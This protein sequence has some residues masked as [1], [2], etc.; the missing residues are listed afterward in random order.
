MRKQHGPAM[1]RQLAVGDAAHSQTPM[2][3]GLLLC[4]GK[5]KRMG[6]DKGLLRLQG[7]YYA[8]ICLEQLSAVVDRVFVSVREDQAESYATILPAA[9]LVVDGDVSA[10]GPLRGL[11]SLLPVLSDAP[12]ESGVLVLPTDM[13]RM[14]ASTLLFLREAFAA[15]SSDAD[16]VFFEM[17]GQL[18]PLCGIYT[19]ALLRRMQQDLLTADGSRTRSAGD[20]GKNI[21][22]SLR[23]RLEACRLRRLPV[24]VEQRGEFKNV[25]WPEELMQLADGD[26]ES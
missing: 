3:V 6:Q 4:G 10:A 12:E 1:S 25:N 7:R 11:L 21:L 19:V 5:G 14:T 26:R 8:E 9:S 22:F 13:P 16:G 24:S 18:E 15:N 17:D 20:S 23:R 2:L